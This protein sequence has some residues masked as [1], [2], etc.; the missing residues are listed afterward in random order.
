[1]LSGY[2]FQVQVFLLATTSLLLDRICLFPFYLYDLLN[3]SL[4]SLLI[5][6]H[7]INIYL[8]LINY[9][10]KVLHEHFLSSIALIL[11]NFFTIFSLLVDFLSLVLILE[12][13]FLNLDPDGFILW[14]RLSGSGAE[15]VG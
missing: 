7:L 8:H 4:F 13:D 2:N 10:I 14:D 12:L 1:M 3:I 5:E 11:L 6:A 9:G 15:A